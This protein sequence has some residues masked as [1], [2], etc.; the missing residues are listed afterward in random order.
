MAVVSRIPLIPQATIPVR[1]PGL[2]ISDMMA[3]GGEIME[4]SPPRPVQVV[5]EKMYIAVGKDIKESISL[6]SWALRNAGGRKICI[7]H[8][9]EPAQWIRMSKFLDSC[10]PYISYVDFM[11]EI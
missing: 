9:H 6:L 11:N 5:E 7:L 1:Y 3:S 2:E 4:E 10:P 8:V